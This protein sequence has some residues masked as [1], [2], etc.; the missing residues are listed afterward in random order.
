MEKFGGLVKRWIK[1][2]EGRRR[3]QMGRA[4]E[5]RKRREEKAGKKSEK[6]NGL[7]KRIHNQERVTF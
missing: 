1:V 3:L 5:K 7:A 4:E 6:R 2:K